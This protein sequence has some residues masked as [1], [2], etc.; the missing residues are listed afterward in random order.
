MAPFDRALT[1]SMGEMTAQQ[2]Y[3]LFSKK[4]VFDEVPCLDKAV[5]GAPCFGK[6]S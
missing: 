5:F 2:C 6:A 1:F 4:N 3:R